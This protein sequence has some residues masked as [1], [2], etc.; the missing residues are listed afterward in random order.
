MN[1]PDWEPD[2]REFAE[3]VRVCEDCREVE[4]NAAALRELTIPPAAFAAVRQRVLGEIQGKKRRAA[5]WIWSAAA[6]VAACAAIVCVPLIPPSPQAPAAIVAK[7]DPPKIEWTPQQA[8]HPA[9]ATKVRAGISRKRGR[10]V[11]PNH[12]QLSRC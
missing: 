4:K 9:R 8:V 7:K 1:C 2:S 6:A 5:W 3:H 10:P 12:L 11:R